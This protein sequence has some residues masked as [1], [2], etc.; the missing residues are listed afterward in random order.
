MLDGFIKCAAATPD[1]RIADCRYNCGEIL[2]LMDEATKNDVKLLVFPELC[3][4][5]CTCM[6]LFSDGVLLDGAERAVFEIAEKSAGKDMLITVGA[7]L[8]CGGRLFN[9]AV[10]IKDGHILGVIPKKRP[11][12]FGTGYEMRNFAPAPDLADEITLG[13]ENIPF[14]N[15]L[16]FCCDDLPEFI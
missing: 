14:G 2:S 7:P 10:V 1:L 11:V 9:C 15:D 12:N 13:G 16:L 8:R 3:V 5:G 6:D 4:T